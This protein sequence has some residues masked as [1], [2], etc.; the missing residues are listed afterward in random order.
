M[1]CGKCGT[2]IEQDNSF[3]ST[4]GAR[5][6]AP[7]TSTRA[8]VPPPPPPLV[9][10]PPPPIIAPPP[11]EIASQPGQ[12]DSNR[13][14]NAPAWTGASAAGVMIAMVIFNTDEGRDIRAWI[15]QNNLTGLVVALVAIAV[16]A[17]I[18]VSRS[19]R[20]EQ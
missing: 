5:A 12:S 13:S 6:V 15:D 4:C 1:F 16:I 20:R 9:V 18:V 19:R 3:C 17:A 2:E 14:S 11:S 7:S 10:P 8:S